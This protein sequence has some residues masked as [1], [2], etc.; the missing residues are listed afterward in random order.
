MN[1]GAPVALGAAG[2]VHT[3]RKRG[4][5]VVPATSTLEARVVRRIGLVAPTRTRKALVHVV[6]SAS[7]CDRCCDNRSCYDNTA[8]GQHDASSQ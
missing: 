4:D 7:L 3:T 5:R 1:L 8:R 6:Y 2:V